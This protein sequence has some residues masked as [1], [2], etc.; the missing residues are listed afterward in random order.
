MIKKKIA[1]FL[2]SLMTSV[3]AV[4]AINQASDL[5][6]ERMEIIN[7]YVADLGSANL[8]D[9][10]SLFEENG[11]VVSISKGSVNAKEF[12]SSFLPEVVEATTVI[13]QVFLGATD[14]N[15]MVFRFHLSFKLKDGE[16]VDGEYI[17]EVVF[18]NNSTLL[19]EVMMFE[20]KKFA[21]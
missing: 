15:R 8:Q 7:R 20:N 5:N 16:M 1:T 19:S 13:H 21:Q 3:S 18:K 10:I 2:V 14:A 17:D 6:E 4:A 9:M 12:F 11:K